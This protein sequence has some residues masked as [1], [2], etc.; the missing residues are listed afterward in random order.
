MSR[1]RKRA[2]GGSVKGH[3]YSGAGSPAAEE[4]EDKKDEFK[5]G[6]HAKKKHGGKVDGHK[7]HHRGDKRPRHASGGR[8]KSPLSGAA[9]V[10]ARSG[11]AE[12]SPDKEDD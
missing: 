3:V 5:R 12:G 10:K 11:F 8:V 4:A 9:S 6:G 7:G 1:M 2:K